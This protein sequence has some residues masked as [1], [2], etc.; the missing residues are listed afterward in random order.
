ML[1][2]LAHA[3]QLPARRLGQGRVNTRC[4]H[5]GARVLFHESVHERRPCFLCVARHTSLDQLGPAGRAGEPPRSGAQASPCSTSGRRT[6][7]PTSFT[8]TTGSW[9]RDGASRRARASRRSRSISM[10]RRCDREECMQDEALRT[11]SS[12]DSIVHRGRSARQRCIWC[13]DRWLCGVGSDRESRAL[14]S[15]LCSA[16]TSRE[17]ADLLRA[18]VG[19]GR[20]STMSAFSRRPKR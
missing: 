4:G 5:K 13:G 20:P 19:A 7:P 18:P 10:P 3:N 17:R 8:S 2:P 16:E 12:V 14:G 11:S 9:R 1:L 6:P 15:E